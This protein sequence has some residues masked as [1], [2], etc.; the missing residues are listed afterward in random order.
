MATDD[1]AAGSGAPE[2]AAAALAARLRH[3]M[4]GALE[5]FTVYLGERLGLYGR[6]PPTGR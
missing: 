3:D 1:G 6:W 5:I 2:D 4:V